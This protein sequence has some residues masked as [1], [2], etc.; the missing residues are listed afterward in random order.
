MGQS[1]VGS[2]QGRCGVDDLL[3][4]LLPHGSGPVPETNINPAART[5]WL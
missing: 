1:G 5:A 3:A 2:K 4:N